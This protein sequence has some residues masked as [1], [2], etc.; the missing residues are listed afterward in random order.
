MCVLILTMPLRRVVDV[1]RDA[2]VADAAEPVGGRMRLALVL[3]QRQQR[4]VPAVGAQPR[5]VVD[6]Q[7]GVVADLGARHALDLVFVKDRRPH[8]TQIDLRRGR[9][10]GARG[11]DHD[12]QTCYQV[13]AFHGYDPGSPAMA[14][15]P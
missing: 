11:A 3:G 14:Y 6:R 4:R 8:A 15:T 2:Q 10:R 9:S 13:R 12:D 5:G 7:A 1:E